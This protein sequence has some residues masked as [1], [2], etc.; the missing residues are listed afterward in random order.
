MNKTQKI[1]KCR[2]I[3]HKY[4]IGEKISDCQDVAFLIKIFE[5]HSEWDIKKGVGIEH[6]SFI[7]TIYKNRCF[8]I[9]RIDGSSTDIS[10]M[11]SITNRS[12][13][14]ILKS[15]CRNAIK[16]EVL[17]FKKNNIILGVSKCQFTA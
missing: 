2:E 8:N 14:Q 4:N 7:N 11:H 5:G 13:I 6:F 3:L 15:A 12:N 16:D 9:N 10:F 1:K 17:S